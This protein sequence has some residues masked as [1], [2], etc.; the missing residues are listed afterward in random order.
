MERLDMNFY[1]LDA[2]TVAQQLLGKEIVR[3]WDNGS[4]SRYVISET[5]AY[6][7]EKTKLSCK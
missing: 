3:R 4:V 7:G 6:Y 1:A 2:V 5:E